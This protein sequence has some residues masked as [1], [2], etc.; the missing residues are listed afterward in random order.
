MIVLSKNEYANRRVMGRKL[1][2]ALRFFC[3]AVFGHVVS[4]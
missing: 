4:V 3:I 2:V 1:P